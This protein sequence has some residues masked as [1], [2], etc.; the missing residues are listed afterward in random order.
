MEKNDPPYKYILKRYLALMPLY[1]LFVCCYFILIFLKGLI[2]NDLSEFFYWIRHSALSFLGLQVLG[3]NDYGHNFG[4]TWFLSVL[5]VATAIIYTLC[6]I[7]RTKSVT[8]LI[9][10]S[11]VGYSYIF[12]NNGKV[13]CAWDSTYGIIS[14]MDFIRGLAD[15]C[16]G[17]SLYILAIKKAKTDYASLI[18]LLLFCSA[19]FISR[20]TEMTWTVLLL[21]S[22]S[23]Y[24]GLRN[25]MCNNLF[26]KNKIIEL[27]TLL[28]YPIYLF[29]PLLVDFGFIQAVPTTN[30]IKVIIFLILTFLIALSSRKV[31]K[32]FCKLLTF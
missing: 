3:I 14:N 19:F 24:F 25:P 9:I 27:L 1:L 23:L 32:I 17:A 15:I 18:E 12:L 11:M 22:C 20:F 7:A 31:V 16:L 29:H 2:K 13:Y 8:V 4:A 28:G 5:I 10:I 26:Y 6:Y 21:L 30:T